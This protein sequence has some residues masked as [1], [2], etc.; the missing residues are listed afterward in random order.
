MDTFY[1]VGHIVTTQGL[2]GEVKLKPETDFIDERFA[3]DSRLYLGKS[4]TSEKQAVTVEKAR[5]QKQFVIVKFA[6]IVD[7]DA[8]E[9]IVKQDV[10]VAEADQQELPAG[11]YYLKDILNL[12]V[13]DAESGQQL[14]TLTD[15]ESPGAN[16]IWEITPD[17]GKK[18]W[19]PNIASVVKKVDVASRRI[20]VTLLEGL[21]DED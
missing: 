7:I 9:K 3:P 21:R 20:E 2:K 11:S 13:F 18:F 4:D 1:L 6:E 17:K 5:L 8:A 15:V 14:G 19:I 16:D 10:F 12:P